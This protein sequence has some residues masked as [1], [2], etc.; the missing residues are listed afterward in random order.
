VLGLIAAT[1][2]NIVT[3]EIPPSILSKPQYINSRPSSLIPDVFTDDS[4]PPEDE[5]SARRGNIFDS[6][7]TSDGS[8][9]AILSEPIGGKVKQE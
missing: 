7:M 6:E 4:P 2:I 5:N 1:I 3:P 9:K 8:T